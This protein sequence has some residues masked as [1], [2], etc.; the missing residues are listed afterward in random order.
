LALAWGWKAVGD[1]ERARARA[2]TV[3]QTAG[4]RGFRLLSLEAR[5][6]MAQLTV[7]EEQQTHRQVGQEL[8]R[9]FT[10]TLSAEMARSFAR[11]PFLKHLDDP[12]HEAPLRA[13]APDD[14]TDVVG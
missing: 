12:A 10:S 2:R 3:L 8:A 5:A 4:S 9:D 11:R 7:D 1:A 6:L 14:P 13:P